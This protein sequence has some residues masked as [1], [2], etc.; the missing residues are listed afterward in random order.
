MLLSVENV[1]FS[2]EQ[3]AP[4]FSNLSL[5]LQRGEI[6]RLAGS[7]G[8]GK[9][10]FLMCLLGLLKFDNGNISFDG[11]DYID[12]LRINSEYLPAECNGLFEDLSAIENMKFWTEL[13]GSQSNEEN[14]KQSLKNWGFK[15]SYLI[16][17]LPVSK[18]STGMK[19]RLAMVRVELSSKK[20]WVLDEPLYGLDTDGIKRFSETLNEHLADEGSALIVS[21]DETIFQQDSLVKKVKQFNLT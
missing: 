7:N 4:L 6:L 10:T 16:E 9:S 14:I 11:S 1:S 20:L 13:N 18:F 12:D 3:H 21:H 8:K 19:R 17:K 2:Y 15:S 5:E